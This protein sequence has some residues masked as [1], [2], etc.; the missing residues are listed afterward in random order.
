M[1]NA[2]WT[3]LGA[4]LLLLGGV[5]IGHLLTS[6]SEAG[7]KAWEAETQAIL[8]AERATWHT[9]V[10][11]LENAAQERQQAAGKAADR[12]R[13]LEQGRQQALATAA[14]LRQRSDSLAHLLETVQG[15]EP[16]IPIYQALVASVTEERDSAT[17]RANT[18]Q[19]IAANWQAAYEAQV[20]ATGLLRAR[21]A[22]DSARIVR[23]ETQLQHYPKADRWK[24][25]VWGVDLRP[26]VG[27]MRTAGG[28]TEV[29]VG[30]F[31]TP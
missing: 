17:A 2:K 21:I 20:E 11:S 10:D 5:L 13:A 12:A 30:L 18:E 26:G 24:L 23:L 3:V 28:D 6:T 14:H 25:S 1:T 16:A 29:G 27:V 8:R 15:A 22:T 4:V 19:R 9:R 31:V 7:R